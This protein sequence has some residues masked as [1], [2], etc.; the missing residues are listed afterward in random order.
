MIIKRF[1]AYVRDE[2]RLNT[3]YYIWPY[4]VGIIRDA[5]RCYVEAEN[6]RQTGKTIANVRTI[7]H[8]CTQLSPLLGLCSAYGTHRAYHSVQH[9]WFTL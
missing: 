9:R 3:L 8:T 7:M 5:G 6:Q 1:G 4:T 2:M